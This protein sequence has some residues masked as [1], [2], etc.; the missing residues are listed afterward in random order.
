[1]P[2]LF[3]DDDV[4]VAA[5]HA[6]RFRHPAVDLPDEFLEHVLA[7]PLECADLDDGIAFRPLMRR[8]EEIVL[9]HGEE[10]LQ[11]PLLRKLEGVGYRIVD[12]LG[13]RRAVRD[14]ML[15][16]LQAEQRRMAALLDALQALARADAAEAIPREPVDIAEL[17]DMPMAAAQGGMRPIAASGMT[18]RL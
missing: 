8:I 6:G 14:E 5:R 13:D 15:A 2:R 16:E 18:I 12:R 10:A 3:G 4:E 7:A 1:M 11:L 9:V 17:A